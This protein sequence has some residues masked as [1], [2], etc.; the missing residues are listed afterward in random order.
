[1][2]A[3]LC[4]LAGLGIYPSSA[5]SALVHAKPAAAMSPFD[6]DNLPED[7]PPTIHRL[8]TSNE[9]IAVTGAGTNFVPP[10]IRSRRPSLPPLRRGRIFSPPF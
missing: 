2:T 4:G 5:P 9:T 7:P 1:L 10:M 6:P 8:R 3:Y